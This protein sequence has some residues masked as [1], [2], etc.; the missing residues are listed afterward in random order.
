MALKAQG[1]QHLPFKILIVLLTGGD[2]FNSQTLES[3]W[4]VWRP[5]SSFVVFVFK[6]FPC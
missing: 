3:I 2:F 6:H 5:F 4:V 1:L